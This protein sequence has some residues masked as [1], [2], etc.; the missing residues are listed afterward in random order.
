MTDYEDLIITRNTEIWNDGWTSS[1][2]DYEYS[3]YSTTTDSTS[4]SSE[5]ITS[6]STVEGTGT[7]TTS[8]S[9]STSTSG[10]TD[11]LGYYTTPGNSYDVTTACATDTTSTSC[12]VN[13][14]AL[15][16]DYGNIIFNPSN[17]LLVYVQGRNSSTLES[18]V[19][20]QTSSPSNTIVIIQGRYIS[21]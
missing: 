7:V 14:T 21:E 2:D 18:Q 8:T 6:T 13:R 1:W 4:T 20:G 16:G 10:G 5:T 15:G 9:T 19:L 12:T 3:Y 11:T 17:T